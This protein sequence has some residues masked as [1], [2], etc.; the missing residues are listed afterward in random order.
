M[1]KDTLKKQRRR[2]LREIAREYRD[3]GYT[4][5][6]EPPS[7]ALPACLAEYPVDLLAKRGPKNV[8]VLVR[9][10]REMIGATDM[11]ELAGVVDPLPNWRLD[12]VAIKPEE[13]EGNGR[14]PVAADEVIDRLDF[15][16]P[17]T[18]PPA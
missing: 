8:L 2:H 17:V 16:S 15:D 12:L 6:V 4:V 9:T 11:V 3:E 5:V 18:T 7:S 13:A 10:R 1:M 14:Q